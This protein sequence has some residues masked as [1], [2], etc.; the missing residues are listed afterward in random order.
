MCMHGRSVPADMAFTEHTLST[1]PD[2]LLEKIF[3]I[4]SLRMKLVCRCVCRSWNSI[5]STDSLLSHTSNTTP[6]RCRE[7]S[8]N[9]C[10]MLTTR[11]PFAYTLDPLTNFWH[12]LHKPSCPGASIL[13]ASH[14]LVCI[15]NQVSECRSLIIFNLLSKSWRLLPNMLHVSLLHKVTM[16]MDP[17][18]HAYVIVVSG[19]DTSEFR[20]RRTYRLHTEV[21]DSVAT[22]WRMAGDAIPEAKFGSDPGVW[23]KGLFY[24][25][26]EMPYG[27][28]VF[29][30]LEGRWMELS[31]EMPSGILHPSLVCCKG[32]LMMVGIQEHNADCD[33]Q[34]VVK[35]N[36]DFL[37]SL[38]T[39][40]I[41]R[42]PWQMARSLSW[43]GP[44][45][46]WVASQLQSTL[47]RWS[48]TASLSS[49]MSR[50][51]S[52]PGS[53]LATAFS[54]PLPLPPLPSKAKKCLRI[55]TL[56]NCKQW[57]MIDE[58]P[59]ELCTEFIMQLTPNTSL[60]CAGVGDDIC[61]S[62]HQSSNAVIFNVNTMGWRYAAS[63]PLFPRSRDTHLLGFA[64][65]P[66]GAC[67]P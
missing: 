25:I 53:P 18:T 14:G 33:E 19:E 64:V 38:S 13:A 66:D 23:H 34:H 52:P 10:F 62:S 55:W 61:I 58:M 24:C 36:L 45:Q 37:G 56:L 9:A 2:D 4:L 31:V 30:L 43:S 48:A 40:Q 5:L 28:T 49:L 8:S 15:G 59:A 41:S 16:A 35:E 29:N 60:L 3:A 51:P 54:T 42:L 67:V 65:Q 1:L 7:G 47:D 21:Y 6:G 17:L 22:S 39:E 46:V 32:R 11:G 50:L 20:G 27:L 26:T 12:K 57:M 63:D 44:L